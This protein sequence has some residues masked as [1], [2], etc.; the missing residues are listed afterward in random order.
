[1]RRL[2][3]GIVF[4]SGVIWYQPALAECMTRPVQD[5]RGAELEYTVVVMPS[6]V[7]AYQ[8]KGYRPRDCR[9]VDAEEM[10]E[11]ICAVAALR[12]PGIQ[13]RIEQAL[14]L[15]AGRICASANR[16]ARASHR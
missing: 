10:R 9:N 4:S 11:K 13:P 14:G 6:E 1:M 12:S 5:S 3:A 7:G 16:A 15:S 8:A 2:I